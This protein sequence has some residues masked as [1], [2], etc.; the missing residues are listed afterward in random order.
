MNVW[1]MHGIHEGEM[2]A[3]THMTEKGAALAA[4]A[5]VFE[6]LGIEDEESATDAMNNS[7]W[8]GVA[9]RA[10]DAEKEEPFEWDFEKMKDMKR[11]EL[12]TIFRQWSELTWD[13]SCGYQ[14]EVNK[15]EIA[16]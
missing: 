4:I 12:W 9:S 6:F 8:R 1:V 5:D 14:V 7:G 10:V 3:S 11:K 2:W 15:T 16:A 13:N